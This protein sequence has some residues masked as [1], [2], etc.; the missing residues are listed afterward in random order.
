MPPAKYDKL[1]W[2]WMFADPFYGLLPVPGTL[3][4]WIM[5]YSVLR[6]HPS[7]RY[8]TLIVQYDTV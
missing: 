8:S 4:E 3:P 2:G 5:L 7:V 6:T 1:L